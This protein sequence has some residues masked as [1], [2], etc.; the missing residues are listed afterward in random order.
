MRDDEIDEID[1]DIAERE[2][3]DDMHQVDD[4]D[5]IEPIDE[6]CSFL[7][8]VCM[9]NDVLMFLDELD[10]NDEESNSQMKVVEDMFSRVEQI[11]MLDELYSKA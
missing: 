8:I 4:V 3:L 9:N 10:D 5:E 6:K 11:E 7:T 1:E 2:H